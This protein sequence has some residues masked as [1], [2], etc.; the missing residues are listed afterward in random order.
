MT[1][2]DTPAVTV[3]PLSLADTDDL[4]VFEAEN[5]Q[6]FESLGIARLP[7]YYVRDWFEDLTEELLEEQAAGETALFVVRDTAQ[8]LV[9]RVNLVDVNPDPVPTADLGYRIGQ[10]HQGRGY[11]TQAV[12][13][14]LQIARDDLGLVR[15]TAEVLPDNVASRRVL[16]KNAFQYVG[17]GRI[18]VGGTMRD[19]DLFSKDLLPKDLLPKDPLSAP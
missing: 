1:R 18:A 12:A 3:S 8:T 14:V 13:A 9:G 5:R 11:A 19:G 17:R 2:A 4:F 6:Y 15:V 16:E 10:A 7:A